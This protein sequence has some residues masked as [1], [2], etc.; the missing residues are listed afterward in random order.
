MAHGVAIKCWHA[1]ANSMGGNIQW[2][3]TPVLEWKDTNLITTSSAYTNNRRSKAF[4]YSNIQRTDVQQHY[5]RCSII[6][7][8]NSDAG[9]SFDADAHCAHSSA[10][11]SSGHHFDNADASF[12]VGPDS[13]ACATCGA[14]EY[15]DD[16]QQTGCKTC[17]NG[18]YLAAWTND[19]SNDAAGDCTDCQAGQFLVG[20]GAACAAC[21]PAPAC[22]IGYQHGGTCAK[23]SDY[24]CTA[25]TAISNAYFFLHGNC[26]FECQP[27]YHDQDDNRSCNSCKVANDCS[28]G[29]AYGGTC[30]TGSDK[31]CSQ[32]AAI[33]SAN[34]YYDTKGTCSHTCNTYYSG[35]NCG[36]YTPPCTSTELIV[37]DSYG[38]G[39]NGNSA[40]VDAW[41]AHGWEHVSSLHATLHSTVA[42]TSTGGGRIVAGDHA[43]KLD[44]PATSYSPE[45]IGCRQNGCY[46][47]HFA[48]FGSWKHEVS[49]VDSG[50]NRIVSTS[51]LSTSNN[52]FFFTLQGGISTARAT[53]N[54]CRYA[55]GI[56]D[57]VL[58]AHE[59][60]NAQIH[61]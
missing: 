29:Y 23:N 52:E 53:L 45:S 13:T 48:D 19:Q 35:T 20:T 54:D 2:D 18:K 33:P 43:H 22:P 15:Q 58:T 31:T 14:G 12:L 26:N 3:A 4:T 10:G 47:L 25:C 8:A 7:L 42:Q 41:T 9:P 60:A 21:K 5:I 1:T 38:D 11:S 57:I 28:V 32:C 34:G 50:G 27:N 51:T 17:A 6:D 46:Q 24:T 30:S 56:S 37:K 36:T 61:R 49:V 40:H 16:T 55:S 39:W 44:G 59:T